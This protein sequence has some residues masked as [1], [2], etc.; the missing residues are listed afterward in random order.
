MHK[1]ITLIAALI[2][3]TLIVSEPG[4][5][6]VRLT[7]SRKCAGRSFRR[8][9][10]VLHAL[11]AATTHVVTQSAQL[12]A[13]LAHAA[14][15]GDVTFTVLTE[16]YSAR[17]LSFRTRPTSAC[18]EGNLVRPVPGEPNPFQN[19]QKT[20]SFSVSHVESRSPAWET[21]KERVFW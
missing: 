13:V 19:H 20:L 4:P 3:F 2:A 6:K 10:W 21:E 12:I 9:V 5:F 17:R 18:M 8:V 1:L 15:N 14:V 16:P 11:T 7:K